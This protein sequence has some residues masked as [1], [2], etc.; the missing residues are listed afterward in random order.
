MLNSIF[1]GVFSRS[2]SPGHTQG[3][4]KDESEKG[5]KWAVRFEGV[6][7]VSCGVMIKNA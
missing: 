3:R 4:L 2:D 7:D 5:F 1:R 6:V